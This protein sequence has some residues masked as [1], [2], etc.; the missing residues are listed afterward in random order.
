MSR[1]ETVDVFFLRSTKLTKCTFL[2]ADWFKDLKSYSFLIELLTS[3]SNFEETSTIAIHQGK[4]TEAT[5]DDINETIN[6]LINIVIDLVVN[7]CSEEEMIVEQWHID[8]NFIDLQKRDFKDFNHELD[9]RW[10]ATRVI[11]ILLNHAFQNV[12]SLLQ[13]LLV[14][15]FAEIWSHFTT[16]FSRVWSKNLEHCHTVRRQIYE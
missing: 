8:N 9:L 4:A 3:I 6:S 13:Q 7:W 15:D 14:E 2:K 12:M 11:E 1:W 5:I 10:W 16:L